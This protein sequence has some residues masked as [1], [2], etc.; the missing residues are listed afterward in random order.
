METGLERL[1]LIGA[2][3]ATSCWLQAAG[4]TGA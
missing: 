4:A 3:H 2:P 1:R